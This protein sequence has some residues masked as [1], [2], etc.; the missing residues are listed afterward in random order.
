ML[1]LLD[2]FWRHWCHAYGSRA[3]NESSKTIKN[4]VSFFL[5]MLS[6]FLIVLH[7]CWFGFFVRLFV[8]VVQLVVSSGSSIL[9]LLGFFACKVAC[10]VLAL[11]PGCLFSARCVIGCFALFLFFVSLLVV[12]LFGR[13]LM[14]FSSFLH[15][16]DILENIFPPQKA[17]PM[18]T[19]S[20]A[21]E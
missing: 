10:P 5:W 8:L 1:L 19:T 15:S 4:V 20:W 13:L 2:L 11:L 6:L 17:N 12:F 9:W 18:T 21:A 7:A 14:S 16:K 3:M